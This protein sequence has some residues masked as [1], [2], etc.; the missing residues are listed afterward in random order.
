MAKKPAAGPKVSNPSILQEIPAGILLLVV[1][2][3]AYFPALYGGM[4]WDDAGHVTG[5]DLQSLHGL[6]R[7]WFELGATQQYYPLLH[8]AFWIEHRMW[9]DAVFGYHLVNV[10]LHA[11]SACL[12]VAILRYLRLP[13]AWLAGFV[14]ALHPVCVEAVAWISEQKSALS[15]CF[16]L[17][18]ALWYLHFDKSRRK[19]DYL[20]A[21]ALFLMALLSKTVT[22]T[23]PAALLVVLWWLRGRISFRRDALPLAPWL[24]ASAGAAAL[25]S[26]VERRFIGAQGADFALTLAQR[27]L[28]AGRAVWFYLGK[29]VWPADLIF[30]YPRWRL[31]STDWLQYVFPLA[32]AAVLGAL[33][34]LALRKGRRGPLAASLF[35]VGTLFPALGFFDVYPFIYSYVADHF[36]YLACLGVIVPVCAGLT[37]AAKRSGASYAVRASAGAALAGVLAVLTWQQSGIYQNAGKL[38]AETLARNPDCWLAHNNLG[39]ELLDRPG[40]LAEAISHF[41]AALRLQPDYAQTYNNMGLALSRI[42]GRLPEAV[43]YFETAVRIQPDYAQAQN[44]LGLALSNFQDRLPEAIA[45]FQAAMRSKP[46]YAQA[47][48]NLG[49]ALSRMPGRLPD[50]VAE[51]QA[52]V[53]ISPDLAE[54]HYNLA[55]ALADMPGRLPEAIAQYQEALRLEPGNPQAHNN[56]GIALSSVPGRLA[57]AI[58]EYQA[59][60][61]IQPDFAAAHYNLGVALSKD[62]SRLADSI[63]ELEAALQI[64]PTFAPA[65]ALLIRLKAAQARGASTSNRRGGPSGS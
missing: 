60:L 23:L 53:R 65:H 39:S 4:L 58:A 38:Y 3:A 11:V 28:L 54:A 14:F 36:Q 25:T 29:L 41:E 44:N 6:W 5:P 26:Y 12:L 31:T 1:T 32:V 46:D 24:A 55:N 13:G 21:S 47:H 51:Y 22:A 56:F 30:I 45:H 64:D 15:A 19:R 62:S 40:Q 7:I 59:A 48:D 2:L 35:F 33:L 18:S 61:R 63:A 20:F 42:P 37:I 16:Y 34:W 50:A 52:A 10:L 57:D 9:G 17:I 27:C 49:T 8:S 43:T